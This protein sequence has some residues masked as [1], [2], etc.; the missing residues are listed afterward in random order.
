MNKPKFI[1]KKGSQWS[2]RADTPAL[3]ADTTRRH[4]AIICR[5]Y[6]MFSITSLNSLSTKTNNLLQV[7]ELRFMSDPEHQ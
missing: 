2:R 4:Y 7:K 3:V 6:P 5:T 1:C